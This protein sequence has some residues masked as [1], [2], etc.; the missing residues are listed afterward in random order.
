MISTRCNPSPKKVDKSLNT[1]ATNTANQ[2]IAFGV[3][4]NIVISTKKSI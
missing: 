3:N 4:K 2:N 1:F